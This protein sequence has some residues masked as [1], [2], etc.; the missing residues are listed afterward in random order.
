MAIPVGEVRLVAVVLKKVIDKVG[1]SVI[2]PLLIDQLPCNSGLSL[3]AV[4]DDSAVK[5]A[6]Q[7]LLRIGTVR[8]G[9]VVHNLLVS[10]ESLMKVCQMTYTELS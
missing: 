4:D 5:G 8:P 10:L 9:I 3:R 7:A 1:D 2:G 6:I